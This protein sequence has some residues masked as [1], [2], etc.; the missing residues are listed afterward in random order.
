MPKNNCLITGGLGFIGSTLA[1]QLI[2][3]KDIS[4]CVLVDNFSGYINPLRQTF[5]DF[6]QER[7]NSFSKIKNNKLIIEKCKFERA[8]CADFKSIY[9]II[10]KY[11]PKYIFHTAA[12]PVARVQNPNISEFREGSIDTTINLLDCIDLLQKKKKLKLERFLYFSSSMI[13]GDFKKKKVSEEDET[14]PKDIYG[15]LKLAGEI[16]VKGLSKCNSI[17]YTIIRPSAVYGPTDMNERVTQYLIMRAI[18]GEKLV[19]HGK[20]E[21]LDFTFIEDL[22][23]GCIKAARSPKGKNET[24]NITFGKA[25]KILDFAKIISK[26]FPKSKLEVVERDKTR[27]KR[28][29]LSTTKARKLLGFKPKIK[30]EQGTQQ[31]INFYKN[32]LKNN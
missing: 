19:V 23:A 30:L 26:N 24:F 14:N 9:N 5:F 32:F 13:Y 15:T 1:K 7:F 17:P 28:G 6:R 21:K 25:R 10:E 31:Y 16:I 4:N 3:F 27:P 18:Q 20:N 8:N 22:A 12:V 11:K 29:T 2:K